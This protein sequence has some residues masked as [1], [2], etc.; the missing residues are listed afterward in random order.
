M[1]NNNQNPKQF[2]KAI[3]FWGRL[4][5]AVAFLCTLTIPLYLTFVLGYRPNSSDIISGM[6]S[7]AGFVGIVWFVEPISYFP[8]LGPAGTYMSFLS[9]NIGNMRLPVIVGTQ[10]AL[11]LAPGS[12]DQKLPVYLH[13][14]HPRSLIWLFWELFL[15]LVRLLSMSCLRRLWLHLTLPCL[16]SWARC[17]L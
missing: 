4:T 9:G 8:T 12:E 14:F 1:T 6:I 3:H 13:S 7:I 2:H 17:S 16:A 10:D 5:I 11:G 15:L